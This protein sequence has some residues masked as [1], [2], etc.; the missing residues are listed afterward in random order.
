MYW[1]NG[2]VHANCIKKGRL[3]GMESEPLKEIREI[4]IAD[5]GKTKSGK[6]IGI[7]G[8]L[9]LCSECK[10]NYSI[11]DICVMC[12]MR[13]EKEKELG[14]GLTQKEWDELFAWLK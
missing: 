3:I 10:L 9:R 13:M 2:V 12:S 6:R 11:G 1:G 4:I 8:R 14:R 7:V 5:E